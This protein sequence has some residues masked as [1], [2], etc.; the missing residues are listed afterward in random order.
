MPELS[1]PGSLERLIFWLRASGIVLLVLGTL[2]V[3]AGSY[4]SSR[5]HEFTSRQLARLQTEVDEMQTR[6]RTKPTAAPATTGR[7]ISQEQHEALVRALAAYEGTRVVVVS[8][9]EFEPGSYAHG[10]IKTLRAAGLDVRV[11]YFPDGETLPAGLRAYWTPAAQERAFKVINA[12]ETNGVVLRAQ[13]GTPTGGVIEFHIGRDPAAPV[14]T[15]PAVDA[16]SPTAADSA[17]GSSA[18]K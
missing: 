12:L 14:D 8:L 7:Q 3:M 10:F 1:D 2:A 16:Q 5:L 18:V 17:P 6:A 13:R 4:Y 11:K 15:Q 9:P